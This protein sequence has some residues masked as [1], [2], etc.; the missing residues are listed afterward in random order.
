[1]GNQ[2]QVLALSNLLPGDGMILEKSKIEA[3]SVTALA[4]PFP[5]LGKAGLEVL[6]GKGWKRRKTE[7]TCFHRTPRFF[8]QYV[9]NTMYM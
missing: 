2:L 1:M 5:R 9:L 3:Q 7:P 6:A 8:S 4:I